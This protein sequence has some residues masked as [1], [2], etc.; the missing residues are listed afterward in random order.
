MQTILLRTYMRYVNIQTSFRCICMK[1]HVP[2]PLIGFDISGFSY[3][4]YMI[5]S[6]YVTYISW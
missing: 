4:V 2:S 6:S 1:L 5:K 3:H